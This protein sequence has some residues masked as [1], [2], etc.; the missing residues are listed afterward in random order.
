MKRKYIKPAFIVVN[1][2]PIEPI[3]LNPTSWQVDDDDV[4]HIKDG[5]PLG[6]ENG[7]EENFEEW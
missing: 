6:G 4:I 3:C 2:T 1:T 5:D 7:D